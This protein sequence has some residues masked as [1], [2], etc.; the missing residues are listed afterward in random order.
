MNRKEIKEQFDLMVESAKRLIDKG[1]DVVAA[2]RTQTR[3]HGREEAA[4]GGTDI[5][6]RV[7][8]L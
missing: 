4:H 1:E 5:G 6:G 2:N 8:K 7:R 3:F